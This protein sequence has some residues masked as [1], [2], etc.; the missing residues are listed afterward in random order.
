ME[1]SKIP[2][3]K[4][5]CAIHLVVTHPKGI[6]ST[7]LA[8]DIGISQKAAWYML[9]R[10]REA[11]SEE[12]SAVLSGVVEVDETY[13]GGKARNMHRSKRRELADGLANKIQVVGAKQRGGRMV[14]EVVGNAGILSPQREFVRRHVFGGTHLYTDEARVFVRLGSQYK[15]RRVNHSKGQYGSG[16]VTTNGIESMWA[17]L[18]RTYIGTHHYMSP[19]HLPRYLAEFVGR[20]NMAYL[21]VRDRMVGLVRRIEGK[22]ISWAEVVG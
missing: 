5:L 10:I 1:A 3:R 11:W 14:A 22:R 4:W 16:G 8:R 6:A 20:R 19:K 9:V 15:H 7:Q 21:P 12:G 18:K 2:L 13:V 17:L